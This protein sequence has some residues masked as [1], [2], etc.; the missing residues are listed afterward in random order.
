MM[1]CC[2]SATSFSRS[3]TSGS[4]TIRPRGSAEQIDAALFL[5]HP[6][7]KPVI[8]WRHEMEELSRDDAHRLL[9][10][11]LRAQQCGRRRRRRRRPGASAR[12]RG[13]D[14]RQGRPPRRDRARAYARKSRRRSRCAHSRSPIRASKCRS[15]QRDYLVPSFTTAKPRRVGGAR[16]SLAYPRQRLQQPALSRAGGRQAASRSWPAPGTE[17][18]R[19]RPIEFGVL[20]HAARPASRCRSSKPAIDAVIA[21]R[22]RQGRHRRRARARQDPA[23]RRRGLCAGQPGQLARWYGAA[24]TTGATVEDVLHWPDRIR[25]VTADAGARCRAAMARQAPFGHRLSDQG[26]EPASGEAL[27]TQACRRA[28]SAL[29]AR[30]V[31]GAHGRHRR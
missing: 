27:M 15:M 1:S 21:E 3:R 17:L 6:Y 5:N 16:G 29:A 20:R 12:A 19:D 2:R 8:G 26:R 4:P 14:L 30:A 9:S 28:R 24:L 31:A 23:D 10:P 7:G 22:H 11:L 25:A 13:R 18:Q